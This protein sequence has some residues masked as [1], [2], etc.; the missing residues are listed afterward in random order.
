MTLQTLETIRGYLATARVSRYE[1]EEF[2][3]VLAELDRFIH[4][5][6]TPQNQAA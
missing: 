2:F 4:K 3:R 1:E 5:V 6:R